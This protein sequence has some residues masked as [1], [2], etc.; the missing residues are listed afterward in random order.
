MRTFIAI[1]VKGIAEEELLNTRKRLVLPKPIYDLMVWESH[2]HVTLRFLGE[3]ND[4]QLLA[5][6]RAGPMTQSPIHA[7]FS[8]GL[9]SLGV[10]L[11]DDGHP[12]VLYAN[13]RGNYPA[14][15]HIQEHV[16]EIVCGLGFPPADYPFKP[17]ITLGYF[18][19][20]TQEEEA[21]IAKCLKGLDFPLPAPF[22][23]RRISLMLSEGVQSNLP[24]KAFATRY[25]ELSGGSLA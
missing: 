17:H 7:G 1:N 25:A 19:K 13:V 23:A 16:D 11:D 15:F 5:L 24:G 3:T 12:K 18:P 8:L 6:K 9:G 20:M 10:F 14:L 21:V 22:E 4:K 2:Y